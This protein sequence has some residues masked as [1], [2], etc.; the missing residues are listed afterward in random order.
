M[1]TAVMTG[2]MRVMDQTGDT[3]VEW[4]KDNVE[5]VAAARATFDALRKK[6]YLAYTMAAGGQKGEVIREFDPSAQKII[7]AKRMV[8]G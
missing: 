4:N 6:D 1:D 3:K 2:E 7:L 5:E 8:G